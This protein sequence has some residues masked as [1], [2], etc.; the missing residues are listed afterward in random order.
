M[1]PFKKDEKAEALVIH[2]S[3][4]RFQAH[5][6]DFLHN[7]LGFIT[8]DR[9]AIPGGPQFFF[10]PAHIPKFEWAGKRWTQFLAEKHGLKEI[11]CI[12]H[13]DCGWYKN[14]EILGFKLSLKDLQL[15]D[16]RKT[17]NAIQEMLPGTKVRLFFAGIKDETVNFTEI[18]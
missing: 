12:A 3:D 7:N 4:H 5:I 2:C 17:E 9:L 16:L 8:Y 11:I 10:T 14:F 13:E 6:D 18:T 1:I 15:N